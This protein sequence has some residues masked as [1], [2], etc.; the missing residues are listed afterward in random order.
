VTMRLDLTA[1]ARK[2]VSATSVPSG[3][4]VWKN[5]GATVP[6]SSKR[7]PHARNMVRTPFPSEM[8]A[9]T[10]FSSLADSRICSQRRDNMSI[11][12]SSS[13][14]AKSPSRQRMLEGPDQKPIRRCLRE[15]GQRGLSMPRKRDLTCTNHQDRQALGSHVCVCSCKERCKSVRDLG[16]SSSTPWPALYMFLRLLRFTISDPGL[17][18]YAYLM[19]NGAR[20]RNEEDIIGM[21][22]SGGDAVGLRLYSRAC[23]ALEQLARVGVFFLTPM[24]IISLVLDRVLSRGGY[25]GREIVL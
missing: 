18:S 11:S 2:G 22:L 20:G 24:R 19:L 7:T 13:S 12:A 14:T 15:Y 10:S 4:H 5:C 8:A 9:P 1:F 3:N 17:T 25:V 21:T 16:T 6:A 23:L